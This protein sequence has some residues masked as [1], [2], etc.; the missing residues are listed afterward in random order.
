MNGFD[1]ETFIK[2]RKMTTL[3]IIASSG[4]GDA[5]HAIQVSIARAKAIALGSMFHFTEST[6]NSL[7]RQLLSKGVNPRR[8]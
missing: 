4:C 7:Q 3:P 2:V 8:I 5:S 6:P 1:I